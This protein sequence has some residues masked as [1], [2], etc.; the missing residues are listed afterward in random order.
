MM[1]VD[2]HRDARIVPA[3]YFH[4]LEVH[5]L[6]EAEAAELGGNGEAVNVEFRETGDDFI[7]DSGL[8]IDLHVVDVAIGVIANAGGLGGSDGLDLGAVAADSARRIPDVVG[9][10]CRRLPLSRAT[11]VRILKGCERLDDVKVNPAVFID[12]VADAISR[13]VYEKVADGI[14][15]TPNSDSWPAEWIKEKH[16]S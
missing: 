14:T 3:E 10:L 1:G 2:E 13:A 6:V 9:D 4:G 12:Q 11:I 16:Q 5:L 15:Y 8:A 7:G